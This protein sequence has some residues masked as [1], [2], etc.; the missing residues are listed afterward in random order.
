VNAGRLFSGKFSV[1][2]S[3]GATLGY[4]IPS[5]V[6]AIGIISF[7]VE[8]DAVLS[9]IFPFLPAKFFSMGGIMLIFAYGIRFFTV[10]YQMVEAGFAKIGIIYTEA[11]RSLGRGVSSTFFLVDL[12][13]IR[14]ALVSGSALVFIDILKELP[15]SLLLRPFNTETLGTTAYHFAKNEVLE[16]TAL[17]SLCIILAGTAFILLMQLWG[18]KKAGHVSGN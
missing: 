1:L 11:S 8:A 6:L 2:F 10:G 7:F 14:H 9:V 17:P 13:M 18:K 12:P 5:A 16:E 4:A 3:Q 15:L